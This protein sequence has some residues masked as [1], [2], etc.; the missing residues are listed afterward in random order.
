MRYFKQE[1]REGSGQYVAAA[2]SHTE[3]HSNVL[4]MM[5]EQVPPMGITHS[6]ALS[7]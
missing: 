3:A 7:L 1:K 5:K 2:L 6:I 4:K